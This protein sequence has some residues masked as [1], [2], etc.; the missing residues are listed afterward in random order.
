PINKSHQET[1]V[2]YLEYVEIDPKGN[3]Y[4]NTW[5]TNIQLTQENENWCQ[6]WCQVFHRA[7]QM[8]GIQVYNFLQ[9]T[10]K[11]LTR[12]FGA[13]HEHDFIVRQHDKVLPIPRLGEISPCN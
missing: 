4:V 8:D 1:L 3:K 12:I 6:N 10:M 5:I 7:L 2:N 13:Q 11:E 9:C